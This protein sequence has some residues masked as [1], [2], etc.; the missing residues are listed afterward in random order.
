MCVAL[1]RVEIQEFERLVAQREETAAK[2]VAELEAAMA[3]AREKVFICIVK[4]REINGREKHH[5]IPP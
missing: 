3:R 1:K 4:E 2:A 5:V